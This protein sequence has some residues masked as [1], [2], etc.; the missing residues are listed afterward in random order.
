YMGANLG[1]RAS[2]QDHAE[3]RTH[4]AEQMRCGT[5]ITEPASV[6]YVMRAILEAI[7]EDDGWVDPRIRDAAF[8]S[9]MPWMVFHD[10]QLLIERHSRYI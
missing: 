9:L 2:C 8:E 4:L 10:R 3:L 5:I 1:L 6:E 7:G